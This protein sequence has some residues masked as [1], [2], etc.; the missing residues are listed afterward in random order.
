MQLDPLAACR[1][2]RERKGEREK[3]KER[4]RA[5]EEEGDCLGLDG[6]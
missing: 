5:G 6:Q 4:E 3:G 2:G 1:V